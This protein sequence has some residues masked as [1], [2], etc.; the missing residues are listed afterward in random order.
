MCGDSIVE[1]F[2]A[3]LLVVNRD[4]FFDFFFVNANWLLL[5]LVTDSVFDLG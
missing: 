3:E 4:G 5:T 2:V 1:N